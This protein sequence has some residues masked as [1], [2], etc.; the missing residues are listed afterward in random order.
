MNRS[1]SIVPFNFQRDYAEFIL[2]EI[3][4]FEQPMN[5]I[6]LSFLKKRYGDQFWYTLDITG[7]DKL[8]AYLIAGA[9]DHDDFGSVIHIYSIAVRKKFEGSG[10]GKK[11]MLN[12]FQEASEE[13]KEAIILEVRDNNLRAIEFYQRLEFEIIGQRTDYYKPG[14][15]AI[16]MKLSL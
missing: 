8:D 6:L 10:W 9:E 3:D 4:R 2:I 15:D 13:N 16:T 1:P 5:R 7:N 11:L 12:L 14:V